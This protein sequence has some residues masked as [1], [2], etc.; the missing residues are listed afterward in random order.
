MLTLV[1]IEF[2]LRESIFTSLELYTVLTKES[3]CT[4]QYTCIMLRIMLCDAILS[5]QYKQ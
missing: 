3:K 2:L 5:L 4:S 1:G